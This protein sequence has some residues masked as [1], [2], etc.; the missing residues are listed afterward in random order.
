MENMGQSAPEEPPELL[1]SVPQSSE[2]LAV[3]QACSA[4]PDLCPA[5]ATAELDH[6]PSE[7]LLVLCGTLMPCVRPCD[8]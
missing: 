8:S 6:F 5:G 3:P 1:E 4:G 2:L 7:L